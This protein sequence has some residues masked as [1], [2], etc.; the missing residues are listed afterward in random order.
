MDLEGLMVTGAAA[1]IMGLLTGGIGTIRPREGPFWKNPENIFPPTYAVC[2][3]TLKSISHSPL[4]GLAHG[5][6]G[7]ALLAISYAVGKALRQ[8]LNKEQ[9]RQ[10]EVLQAMLLSPDNT[11]SL[12]LPE[13]A[14][15][16]DRITQLIEKGVQE[17]KQV[18][19]FDKLANIH[20]SLVKTFAGKEYGPIAINWFTKNCEYIFNL[21][22]VESIVARSY[23]RPGPWMAVIDNPKLEVTVYVKESD[24]FTVWDFEINELRTLQKDNSSKVEVGGKTTFK[25]KK[26]LTV[27]RPY[28]FIAKDVLD[29]RAT[30]KCI[31]LGNF[32]GINE[33]QF[34]QFMEMTL[35]SAYIQYNK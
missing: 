18:E 6:V 25:E 29:S 2:L 7:G 27:P 24:C 15:A 23:E 19:D 9:R 12:L 26:Y 14:A 34:P 11:Y 17:G 8:K 16:F 3:G 33:M 30:D 1:T 35:L 13:E 10:Q 32:S 5:T 4:E 31:A 22:K 21:A 20:G 28:K